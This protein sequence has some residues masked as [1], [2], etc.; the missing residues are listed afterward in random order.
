MWDLQDPDAVKS[1]RNEARTRC[2]ITMK[3]ENMWPVDVY[4]KK[5]LSMN[6]HSR[7]RYLKKAAEKQLKKPVP[8]VSDVSEVVH[9]SARKLDKVK[10]ENKQHNSKKY[11]KAKTF[12]V[13]KQPSNPSTTHALA[14]KLQVPT[15]K[16]PP[17]PLSRPKPS[18][19]GSSSRSPDTSPSSST[20][21]SDTA[22]S[23]TGSG[24]MRRL[25]P[26]PAPAP[27]PIPT[28]GEAVRDF[29]RSLAV[30]LEDF[31]PV[32]LEAGIT[33]REHLGALA[34]LPQRDDYLYS[35]VE[36]KLVGRFQ[37]QLIKSGLDRI[38]RGAS[39]VAPA[40][41][42]A[43]PAAAMQGVEPAPAAHEP[44]PAPAPA[45]GA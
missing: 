30:S 17:P 33:S 44:A 2:P 32:F 39:S 15:S 41:Q 18:S 5:Y 34:K 19:P 28:E 16:S 10:R 12:Y 6:I 26:G 1:Y 24:T 31:L 11:H 38:A 29:L 40:V 9:R 23:S 35:F 22:S 36:R 21:S 37:L 20:V 43:E 27:M 7:T 3:Y 13:G 14:K 4:S 42:G 8:V 25:T 45:N